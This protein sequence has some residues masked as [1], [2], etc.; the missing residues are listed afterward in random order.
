MNTLSAQLTAL[1][2]QEADLSARILSHARTQGVWSQSNLSKVQMQEILSMLRRSPL[3]LPSEYTIIQ[4]PHKSGTMP[5]LWELQV[6]AI[7]DRTPNQQ[8]ERKIWRS[9]S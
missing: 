7:S 1:S 6:R 9:H 5:T 4:I 2:L 8:V 3:F